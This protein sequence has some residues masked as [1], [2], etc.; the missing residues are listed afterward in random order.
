MLEIVGS[1]HSWKLETSSS[2]IRLSDIIMCMA[3]DGSHTL[4]ES[5]IEMTHLVG[6]DALQIWCWDPD[7]FH[8]ERYFYMILTL[9]GL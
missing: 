8:D 6:S 7:T 4:M 3:H 1:F 5:F 2:V 9:Y